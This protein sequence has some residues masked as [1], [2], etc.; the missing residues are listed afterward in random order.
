M[1]LVCRLWFPL[2]LLVTEK[3]A[4]P[5]TRG[6]EGEGDEYGAVYA[7]KHLHPCSLSAPHSQYLVRLLRQ[8]LDVLHR[9]S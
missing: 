2:K 6:W 9:H 5:R 3:L 4:P 1:D 7:E 8:A